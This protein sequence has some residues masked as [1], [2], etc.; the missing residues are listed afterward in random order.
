[1]GDLPY[2]S[3]LPCDDFSVTKGLG[4]VTALNA[5]S[6]LAIQTKSASYNPD[7]KRAAGVGANGVC[8]AQ[9]GLAK[10]D[11]VLLIFWQSPVP[12]RRLLVGVAHLKQQVFAQGIADDL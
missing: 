2:L 7:S 10:A 5:S 8:P 9:P 1:M 12:L 6:L 4:E 3:M 11:A